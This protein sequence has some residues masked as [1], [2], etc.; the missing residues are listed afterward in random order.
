MNKKI[1]QI[2]SFLFLVLTVISVIVTA[3][4]RHRIATGNDELVV[5][6]DVIRRFRA[7]DIKLYEIQS[8]MKKRG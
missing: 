4:R 7:P 2:M 3:Y 1:E 6:A 8:I 5:N